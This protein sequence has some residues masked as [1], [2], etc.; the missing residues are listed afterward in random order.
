MSRTTSS[1]R[2]LSNRQPFPGGFTLIELLVVIAIIA[3]LAALLLPALGQAK[4][5]ARG[6]QCMGNHRQLCLAWRMYSDDNHDELLFASEDP[7]NAPTFSHA[8]ITG[9]L[10]F[11]PANQS[12]WDPSLTIERSPLWPYCGKNLAIWK[13]P[14]DTSFVVVNG[15]QKPRVRSM[16]MN[17]YLGGF[18]G[19]FGGWNW[20]SFII[21]RKQSALFNPGPSRIFVFLDM[22]QDS[23]DMGNFATDMAGWP[24]QPASY[25]F[26]DLPGLYHGR[27]GGFS[28]ADGHAEI[29][30]WR[31][32]RT[33]PPLVPEGSV[34]DWFSS[35]NNPDVAWLQQHAT[36]PKQ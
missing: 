33:M 34:N 15:Q 4:L 7:T 29:H 31:D 22:R 1:F 28:F 3:I 23:I 5:K 13:C 16:S 12:N 32:D 17:V 11:N 14:A 30:P 2:L 35:P 36:R 18:G 9:Q 21:Y 19:T 27:A 25:G 10:D 26:F 8:W 6:I 24:D 20:G